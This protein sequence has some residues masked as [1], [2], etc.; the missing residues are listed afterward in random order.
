MRRPEL[1]R[2]AVIE[3]YVGDRTNYARLA[4]RWRVDRST[5]YRRTQRALQRRLPLL[6]RTKRN[7]TRCD[8]VV[9]L[10]GKHLRILGKLYTIFVAWDRGFKRP[11]H[12]LLRAGGEGE[13]GYWKLMIDLRH[14]GYEPIAFISD[15][16][17]SLKE[18]LAEMYPK[19][20]H[21]RCTVHLFLAARAKAAPRRM[22]TVRTSEFIEIIRRILWSRS[23]GEA[24]ARLRRVWNTP[25]LTPRERRVLEFIWPALPPCFVCRDPQWRH[26][27][28]PRSSNAIENVIGQI[29]ARLKTMR[30]VK[31]ERAATLLINELLLRVKEQT[32]NQ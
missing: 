14:A 3:G 28:L 4:R 11:I 24:Q 22:A 15:G 23:L 20:P 13:L 30:G 12:F 18:F 10:D 7:L 6:A 17:L 19:L 9:V 29:E 16:I 31:S 27:R 21:Q 32:I 1:R 2:R 5:V 8:R 26:L 25:N